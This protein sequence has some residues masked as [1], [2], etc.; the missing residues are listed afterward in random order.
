VHRRRGAL[1]AAAL[2]CAA[3]L[4]HAGTPGV[5]EDRFPRAATAY[6]VA[7]DG[8][9][10]WARNVAQPLEPASLTKILTAIVLLERGFDPDRVITVSKRAAALEGTRLALRAGERL[11]AGDA[12]TAMLVG[13]ANDA[14]LALA[15]DAAG[16]VERFVGRLNG[17]AAELGLDGT[18]FAN[19]CGLPQQGHVTTARD[20]LR[21][22]E[23]A[24]AQPEFARRVALPAARLAT[25][26]GRPLNVRTTNM[27]IGRFPG[28]IGVKTGYTSSAGKCLVALAERDGTRV[29][30]VLLDAPERWWTAAALLEE[31]FHVARR[32][33]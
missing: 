18:R 6:L 7:I 27:L 31:S 20:L 4:A 32:A 22:A 8:E 5:A 24:M 3:T 9:V 1:A 26:D 14:C 33:R 28:A 17:R 19:P 10:R 16:S 11:R 13:S 25:L 21:M 12:L 15:E 23:I 30:V 2:A 29:V